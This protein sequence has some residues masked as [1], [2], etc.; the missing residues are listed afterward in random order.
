MTCICAKLVGSTIHRN[1]F[2]NSH[3]IY[4]YIYIFVFLVLYLKAMSLS[5]LK[6]WK[7]LQLPSIVIYT[8]T[9]F[10][11]HNRVCLWTKTWGGGGYAFCEDRKARGLD[12]DGFGSAPCSKRGRIYAYMVAYGNRYNSGNI[13]TQVAKSYTWVF[14]I[15]W[16]RPWRWDN[17][18]LPL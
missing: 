14:K 15:N 2:I 8:L 16:T 17:F 10:V 12:E 9:P 1:R 13:Y 7:S 18:L 3:W 11:R 5:S 4:I 6:S